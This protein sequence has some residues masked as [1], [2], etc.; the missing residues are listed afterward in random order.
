MRGSR[1]SKRA[2]SAAPG[3]QD[4]IEG[5]EARVCPRE[6]DLFTDDHLLMCQVGKT[7]RAASMQDSRAEIG[8]RPTEKEM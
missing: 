6:E 8:C 2:D 1:R 3:R 7:S 5:S 4:S